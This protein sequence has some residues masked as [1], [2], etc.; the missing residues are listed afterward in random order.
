MHVE[1]SDGVFAAGAGG[2]EM[3]GADFD[4]VAVFREAVERG[5]HIFAR[6][7]AGSEFAD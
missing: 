6:N 5:V 2:D 3:A 1:A 7:A 4:D